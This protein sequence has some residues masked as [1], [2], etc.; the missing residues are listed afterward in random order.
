MT[1]AL[2]QYAHRRGDGMPAGFGVVT[3]STMNWPKDVAD[4]TNVIFQRVLDHLITISLV[5]NR[6]EDDLEVNF[7]KKVF[8]QHCLCRFQ[9][10]SKQLRK[11]F[12]RITLYS[13]PIVI[14]S[15]CF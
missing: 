1:F 3:G 2:T 8:R 10:N 6:E 15:A 12:D 14:P 13:V 5:K 4:H 9:R 7:L 11:F